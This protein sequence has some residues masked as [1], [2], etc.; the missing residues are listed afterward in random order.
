MREMADQ[1]GTR[2]NIEKENRLGQLDEW[3]R[4]MSL[5]HSQ[6]FINIEE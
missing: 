4:F 1:D 2:D 5:L 3:M 6:G